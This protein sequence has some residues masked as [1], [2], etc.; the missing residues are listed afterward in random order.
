[1][2]FHQKEPVEIVRVRKR[3]RTSRSR[4][5]GLWKGTAWDASMGLSLCPPIRGKSAP[6]LTKPTAPAWGSIARRASWSSTLST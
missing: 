5:G 2:S 3:G 4:L 1:M 6:F